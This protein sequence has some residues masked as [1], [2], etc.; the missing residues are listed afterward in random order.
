MSAEITVRL[1]QREQEAFLRASRDG[2]QSPSKALRSA[3]SKIQKAILL[4][5][6]ETSLASTPT[7]ESTNA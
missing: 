4:R 2:W 6:V 3:D 5:A 7:Q 1:T